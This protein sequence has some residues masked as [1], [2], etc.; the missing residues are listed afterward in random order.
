MLVHLPNLELFYN[1]SEF[2]VDLESG[3]L[4]VKLQ[5]RW[6]PSGLACNKDV[7]DYIIYS[8]PMSPMMRKNYIKDRAQAAMTYITEYGN[9]RLWA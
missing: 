8:K 1:T 3:K 4:F 2:L 9:T 5:G 6:H 7:S